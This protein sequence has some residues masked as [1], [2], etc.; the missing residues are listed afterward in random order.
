MAVGRGVISYNIGRQTTKNFLFSTS[1]SS[2]SANIVD[3]TKQKNEPSH[4]YNEEQ[5]AIDKRITISEDDLEEKFV[6]G[7]GPGGQK[8]NKT[9]NCVELKHKHTGVIIKVNYCY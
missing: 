7:S 8:V 2:S 1:S 4:K 6:R 3:S 9:S 5:K